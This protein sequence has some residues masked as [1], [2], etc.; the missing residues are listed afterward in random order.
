MCTWNI[1][2]FLCSLKLTLCAMPLNT[3][4]ISN[5]SHYF[6]SEWEKMKFANKS[7]KRPEFFAVPL[8]ISNDMKSLLK[9]GRS[10]EKGKK[11][12][13]PFYVVCIC[14]FILS[15]VAVVSSRC[16]RAN[17]FDLFSIEPLVGTKHTVYAPRRLWILFTLSLSRGRTIFRS[18][19]YGV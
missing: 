9:V 5:A 13:A 14:S 3:H 8:I 18:S 4:L 19:L 15:S 7:S 10:K 11:C 12:S 1:R 16:V 2:S 6:D 17:V